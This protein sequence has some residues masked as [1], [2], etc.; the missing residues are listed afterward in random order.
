MKG[1][2]TRATHRTDETLFF[3]HFQ[4][5][6]VKRLEVVKEHHVELERSRHVELFTQSLEVGRRASNEDLRLVKL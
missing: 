5:D 1:N 6:R 2:Q 3:E 4:V